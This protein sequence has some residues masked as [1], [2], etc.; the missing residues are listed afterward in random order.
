[1]KP[2]TYHSNLNTISLVFTMLCLYRRVEY[3]YILHKHYSLYTAVQ[4]SLVHNLTI[5]HNTKQSS[6]VIP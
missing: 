3:V 1:M 6:I 2:A 4:A 5:C